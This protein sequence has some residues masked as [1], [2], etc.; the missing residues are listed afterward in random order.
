[1][2]QWHVLPKTLHPGG[3]QSLFFFSTY[4]DNLHIHTPHKPHK[5]FYSRALWKSYFQTFYFIWQP[6]MMFSCLEHRLLWAS[7]HS[8]LEGNKAED[9]S[10]KSQHP[11][12]QSKRPEPSFNAA[13]SLGFLKKVPT[14]FTLAVSKSEL[15]SHC[16][17]NSFLLFFFL[18]LLNTFPF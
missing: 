16:N 9:D 17:L 14:S 15:H 3:E 7:C 6:E 1:M 2:F 10:C 18:L 5:V 13:R 8:P 4:T 12:R 11:P